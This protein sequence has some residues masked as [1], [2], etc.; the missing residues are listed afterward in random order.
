MIDCALWKNGI[1]IG[2]GL[3]IPVHTPNAMG[4]EN[5]SSRYGPINTRFKGDDV[6]LWGEGLS[7][8]DMPQ[9]FTTA[10]LCEGIRGWQGKLPV[11]K[12]LALKERQ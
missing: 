1:L 7:G 5:L 2:D 8:L 9:G 3:P 12:Q 10:T 11:G 4:V 6:V